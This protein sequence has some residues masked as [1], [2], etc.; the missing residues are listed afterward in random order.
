MKQHYKIFCLFFLVLSVTH[1][2]GCTSKGK[3]GTGPSNDITKKMVE[4]CSEPDFHNDPSKRAIQSFRID[5]KDAD[6]NLQAFGASGSGTICNSSAVTSPSGSPL[7]IKTAL[8]KTMWNVSGKINFSPQGSTGC[9]NCITPAFS[10]VCDITTD[11]IGDGNFF[12]DTWN[13]KKLD[14]EF[15]VKNDP[16]FPNK[17]VLYKISLDGIKWDV[18]PCCYYHHL[19]DW[20]QLGPCGS[21]GCLIIKPSCSVVKDPKTGNPVTRTNCPC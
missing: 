20:C 12:L 9:M 16:R 7:I 2:I 14:L 1:N 13:S 21:R 10:G 8:G 17:C 6:H 4:T 15:W 11:D 19:E 5:L 18:E 3:A